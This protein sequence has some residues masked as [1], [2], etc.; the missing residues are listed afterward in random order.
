MGESNTKR[1]DFRRVSELPRTTAL[2]M[3]SRNPR[4][5]RVLRSNTRPS[6]LGAARIT[7]AKISPM[8]KPFRGV[9]CSP[10]K[11]MEVATAIKGLIF[12]A[13]DDTATPIRAIAEYRK[14]RNRPGARIP[15]AKKNGNARRLHWCIGTKAKSKA[16]KTKKVM[17][18]DKFAAVMELEPKAKPFRTA[19]WLSAYMR[20]VARDKNS[21]MIYAAVT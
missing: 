3:A 2:A 13:T 16:K 4:L 1:P 5:D 15:A 6:P 18:R 9:S 8:P 14:K 12:V 19:M 21:I 20:A 10:R 7:A 11:A 17:N